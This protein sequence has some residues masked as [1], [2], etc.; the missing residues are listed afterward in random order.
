MDYLKYLLP[1]SIVTLT[2]LG[3]LAGSLW[4]WSGLA[5]FALILIPDVM[6]DFDFAHREMSKSGALFMLWI[7]LIPLTFLWVCFWLFLRGRPE[8]GA[9]VGAIV[10]VAI[11]TGAAGL[12][13]SHELFHRPEWIS[14]FVGALIS[15][16]FL[17][18]YVELEH[19]RSHH[20]ETSSALD[21]DTPPRGMSVYP[22][23]PRLLLY[24]HRNSIRQEM[25][26]L[27]AYGKS[28]WFSP[29]SRVFWQLVGSV[30]AVA[31]FYAADGWRSMTAML[32]TGLLGSTIVTV[33]SYVQHYGL[34]RVPGS[35]IEK[36]HA[37]NHTRPISR[38]LTFEI[39]THSGHHIDPSTPYW[40]LEPYRDVP[41]VGSAIACFFICLVP[42]LW[43]PMM[44]RHLLNWDERF[45]NPA[46]R[47]LARRANLAAGWEKPA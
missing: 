13:V 40:E 33:F 15:T 11:I 39:V 30:A 29:Q 3:V 7:Q 32:A 16:A 10:S 28:I 9:L 22:F 23:I 21:V 25:R 4:A 20:I 41:L 27:S 24:I 5:L 8:I 12:P 43:H 14:R 19:N 37:W 35:P 18:N 45:A 2:G 26:R 36:R 38:I 17:F 34:I 31:I 1:F 44:R 47:E 42:P 46:E 6:R